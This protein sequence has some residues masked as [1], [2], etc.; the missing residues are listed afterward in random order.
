MQALVEGMS[1]ND[2]DKIRNG[3]GTHRQVWKGVP[4][5]RQRPGTFKLR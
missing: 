3:G 1:E 5:Y 4:S 2:I